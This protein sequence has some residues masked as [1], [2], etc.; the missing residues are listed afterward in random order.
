MPGASLARGPATFEHAGR[1][2]PDP[3]GDPLRRRGR[4]ERRHKQRP[5][6]GARDLRG[7]AR[8]RAPTGGIRFIHDDHGS[9]GVVHVGTGAFRRIG[10]FG[11]DERI[12]H[13][14]QPILG[15]TPPGAGAADGEAG[16]K[17]GIEDGAINPGLAAGNNAR[18]RRHQLSTKARGR[19]VS[20]TGPCSNMIGSAQAA[21]SS[22]CSSF[23]VAASAS[24]FS[25]AASSRASR[26]SA[27]S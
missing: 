18:A 9:V 4:A 20:G 7:K 15:K 16:G 23:T 12:A 24:I 3:A 13:R 1:F 2:G 14:D 27:A 6:E 22:T 8:A 11:L 19:C 21:F 10:T 17:G 5:A 26:S 25:T